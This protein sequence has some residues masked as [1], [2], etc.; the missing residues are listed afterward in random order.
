MRSHIGGS[1]PRILTCVLVGVALV[2]G[3]ASAILTRTGAAASTR[4]GGRP[5]VSHVAHGTFRSGEVNLATLPASRIAA[6]RPAPKSAHTDRINKTPA[7]QAAY[8]QWALSHPG[9]LPKAVGDGAGPSASRVHPNIYGNG[10]LPVLQSAAAGLTSNDGGGFY[11]PD[12]AISAAPGYV[13]EGVNNVMVVYNTTYG[14]KYGPW[15]P[16][17]FFASV[18]QTGDVF[19]DPQITFDAERAKYLISW[20]EI[21]PT[22]GFDYLDIAVSRDSSPTPLGNFKV[23]QIPAT[24]TGADDFCDYDT[25]GYDFWGMYVTCVTY[26]VSS[27]ALTG[28]RTYDFD[29]NQLV[30]GSA[31]PLAWQGTVFT[32][33]N[34]ATACT[35]AYRVSPTMEDGVPQT[36]WITATDV[37]FGATSSNLTVCALTNTHALESGVAPTSSCSNTTLPT[38]YD[39]SISAPQ[40]G[41]VATIYP[42]D[43]YKQVAYRNGQ[44]YFALPEA[45]NCGG[46]VVD[47]IYWAAVTPQLS[48]IASANPQ[49]ANGIVS[50]YTNQGVFCFTG[51]NDYLYMPTL[52]AGTEGD[53]VLVFNDSGPS[54]EP[55]IYFTG[56]AAADAPGT[57]AQGATGASAWS[58]AVAGANSNDSGRWGDYSN[59]ALTTNLVTR[60]IVFCGGEFGGPNTAL[61]SFGWDTEL[62]SIRME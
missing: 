28:N 56:R 32:S 52:V 48:T 22:T 8:R 18:K 20:L 49:T 26:S 46:S 42:G 6:A 62:Y 4:S 51:G 60:G 12:Q 30:A 45:V 39:D 17:T 57:M 14:L 3:V 10:I 38:S 43:G 7:Q 50:A 59:C 58:T 27:G 9:A 11:P 41:T 61:G 55:G 31:T 23:Y 15:T 29:I 54:L 5:L 19:S 16:D 35:P 47:G 34:C 25:L 13:I 33:L 1:F 53:M 37:G 36:E 21:S 40:P 44:I 2:A 24:T